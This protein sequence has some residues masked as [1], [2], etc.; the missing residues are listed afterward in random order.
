ML[1]SLVV[2]FLAGCATIHEARE[3]QKALAYKGDDGHAPH[4]CERVDLKGASLAQLV[5]FA[6]TN[7][8]SIASKVLAVEDARLA[9]R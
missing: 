7:R 1:V 8:P 4:P 9:L 3:V 5:E 6:L 2:A